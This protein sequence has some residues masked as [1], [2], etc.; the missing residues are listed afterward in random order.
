MSSL[1]QFCYITSIK[2][3]NYKEYCVIVSGFTSVLKLLEMKSDL[4]CKVHAGRCVEVL[5]VR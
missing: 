5:K 2:C 3:I 4:A 1:L